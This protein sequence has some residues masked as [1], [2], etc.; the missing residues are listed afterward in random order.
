MATNI[1]M[2]ALEMAQETGVLVAWLIREGAAVTKGDALISVETD[3][4]TVDIVATTSGI[5]GPILVHEGDVVPVGQTVGWI[6][7]PGEAA[8]SIAPK[9]APMARSAKVETQTSMGSKPTS[10]SPSL[11]TIDASPVAKNIAQENGIDLSV[12]KPVGKRIE[13]SDVLDFLRAQEE[14]KIPPQSTPSFLSGIILA[15]PKARRLAEERNIDLQSVAG[16]G[17]DGAIL[18]EDILASQGTKLSQDT[19]PSSTPT[20]Y[21]GASTTIEN[22]GNIWKVMAERMTNSWTTVPHFYLTREVD[23]SALLEWRKRV[24]PII[25]KRTGVKPTVTDLLVKLIG[26]TLKDHPRLNSSWINGEIQRNWEVNVGIATALDEGLIVPVIHSVN[27]VS[28]GEISVQRKEL[29]DRA[30]NR[31]LHPADIS[32]GTFTLSN[33]GMYNVDAFCAIVNAPQA[34]ILA[35][36]KIADRVVPRE[37]QVV[38]RPM[39]VMTLSCDH[40]V[41]DGARAA[42]FLDDLAKLIEDPWGLLS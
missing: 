29:I 27:D 20:A 22:V 26:F 2:P 7:A 42:R 15:S 40:R 16:S 11:P 4:V 35:V 18:A 33:L 37:G 12:I 10:V 21:S 14:E 31:K 1:I 8:P 25:E 6:L 32:G 39:M 3:K 28:L 9:D 36:G 19:A 41:V 38:I 24:S 30:Q 34:A 23:A 17:P 13:K 5:L